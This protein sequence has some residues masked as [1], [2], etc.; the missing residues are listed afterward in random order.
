MTAAGM[1]GGESEAAPAMQ[2][3]GAFA[4]PDDHPCLP[5]HFPGR[6]VVPGALLLDRA[7]ALVLDLLPGQRLA[8]IASAKFTRPV[9]PRQRVEVAWRQAAPGR[10]A[11][12]CTVAGDGVAQGVALIHP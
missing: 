3:A 4:I 6:P 10:V 5:G 1:E 9:L 8:G 7:L 11:F 12:R 2:A